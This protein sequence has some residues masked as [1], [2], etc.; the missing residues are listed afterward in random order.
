M[1]IIDVDA[2]MEVYGVR[3]FESEPLRDVFR[4]L[5]QVYGCDIV[6]DDDRTASGPLTVRT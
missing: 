2:R 4:I 6:F 1:N 3:T 5:E